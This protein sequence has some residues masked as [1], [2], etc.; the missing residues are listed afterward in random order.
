MLAACSADGAVVPQR[1]TYVATLTGSREIPPV[2]TAASGSA[3]FTLVGQTVT[4]TVLASGFSTTLTVGHA[5][6]GPAGT[7]GLVIVP[8]TIIAQSGT[9]ASG[10]LD[11]SVPI[12]FGN[13]TIS[14]DSLRTLFET[15][16]AYVN[17]HTAAHPGGE[18]RGQIVKQ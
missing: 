1:A 12:T 2:V 16:K 8:L 14:G 7:T 10:S 3:T 9:V 18:I 6:I 17:L 5:L 4:Y 11:L 13:V 15:G